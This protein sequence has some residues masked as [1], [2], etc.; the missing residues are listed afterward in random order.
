MTPKCS[1]KSLSNRTDENSRQT[2]LAR[3]VVRAVSRGNI[4][5][6]LGRYLTESDKEEMR[7]SMREYKIKA[8]I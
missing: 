6:Q 8:P 4:N 3:E 7:R 5:L 2:E 1:D